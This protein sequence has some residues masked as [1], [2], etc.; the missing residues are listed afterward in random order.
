[1]SKEYTRSVNVLGQ[2]PIAGQVVFFDDYES[3]LQWTK[4]DGAGDSIFELDP[5]LSK[6]GNQSLYMETRTTDMAEDDAI[7]SMRSL[8]LL[9][10]KVMSAF[11]SIYFKSFLYTKTFSF[12]L[13]FYDGTTIHYATLLFSPNT[14]KWEF[15]NS[16]GTY[17]EIPSLALK[18]RNETW[19]LLNLKVNFSTGYY[20]S[21]QADHQ[22]IDLSGNGLYSD[23]VITDTALRLLHEIT[24]V[25]LIS[26]ATLNIDDTI[27]HEL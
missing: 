20:L 27:V 5:T 21:F 15:L 2:I 8:H 11:T 16:G 14:P 13:Q 4:I 26:P 9:P 25:G 3:I 17:T 18:F 6:H 24:A 23:G 12:S 19:H 7:S 1:M 10:S 22:I